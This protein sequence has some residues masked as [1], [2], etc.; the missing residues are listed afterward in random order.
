[1]GFKLLKEK[2]N[3]VPKK[4]QAQT[5][6][7]IPCEKQKKGYVWD[8]NKIEEPKMGPGECSVAAL[9]LF[10]LLRKFYTDNLLNKEKASKTKLVQWLRCYLCVKKIKEME[11]TVAVS[12]AR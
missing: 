12:V 2:S 3:V 6:L 5:M 10:L 4:P 1:M 9:I 11:A 7:L 8:I